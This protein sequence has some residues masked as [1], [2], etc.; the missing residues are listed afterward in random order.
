MDGQ[1]FLV[2]EFIDGEELKSRIAAD[3]LPLKTLFDVA[4]LIAEG[5]HKALQM[6][7]VHRDINV[8]HQCFFNLIICID[9]HNIK[10]WRR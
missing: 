8:V 9:V 5:L 7:I 3:P 6:G 10:M 2:M 4:E 1:T